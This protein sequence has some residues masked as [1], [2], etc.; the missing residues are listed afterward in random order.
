MARRAG[1]RGRLRRSGARHRP[2][3]A[4]SDLR[5]GLHQPDRVR[6]HLRRPQ[7]HASRSPAI[8]GTGDQQ[9]PGPR[10]ACTRAASPPSRRRRRASV[11]TPRRSR[12]SRRTPT[13]TTATA[14]GPTTTA[15]PGFA[16]HF[17][18]L[19]TEAGY[20]YVYVKDA[21]GNVLATY[22]GT[23]PAPR[24]GDDALHPDPAPARCSWSP[25]WRSPTRAS[26]S[27]RSSRAD[28]VT[29]APRP[30]ARDPSLA[31]F[32]GSAAAWL[33]QLTQ[34]PPFGRAARARNHERAAR[35]L[36]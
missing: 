35:R 27:T 33:T 9:A 10:S 23:A 17:S 19:E 15:R 29:P 20:D 34:E 21:D 11:T 31:E 16:F 14:P 2:A 3:T 36:S 12:S 28:E 8:A 6:Q 18:L 5:P 7:R 30:E 25:T 4:R 13:G 32:G 1:A 22:D 26:R 24:W